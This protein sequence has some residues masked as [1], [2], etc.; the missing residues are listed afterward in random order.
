MSHQKD[1]LS[2][3]RAAEETD[4]QKPPTVL[5][6]GPNEGRSTAQ[7]ALSLLSQV[8]AASEA[9]EFDLA[10]QF[11]EKLLDSYTQESQITAHAVCSTAEALLLTGSREHTQRALDLCLR[12]ETE[13]QHFPAQYRVW[14]L[15][16]KACAMTSVSGNES[17]F[18]TLHQFKTTLDN[19][20]THN[21]GLPEAEQLYAA[22]DMALTTMESLH[23][24]QLGRSVCSVITK[25]VK[26][27]RHE[28]THGTVYLSMLLHS[29][30]FSS[31]VGEAQAALDHLCAVSAL[32]NESVPEGARVELNARRITSQLYKELG[33]HSRAQEELA[34][35]LNLADPSTDSLERLELLVDQVALHS[36]SEQSAKCFSLI[37][38]LKMACYGL[39]PRDIGRAIRSGPHTSPNTIEPGANENIIRVGTILAEVMVH[40]LEQRLESDPKDEVIPVLCQQLQSVDKLLPKSGAMSGISRRILLAR[41]SA[42][43]HTDTSTSEEDIHELE[44]LSLNLRLSDMGR[45]QVKL[46]LAAVHLKN[47]DEHAAQSIYEEQTE[48]LEALKSTQRSRQMLTLLALEGHLLSKLQK[49]EA[50]L[51]TVQ[52]KVN[53]RESL[54]L[55]NCPNCI[56]DKQLLD[57][58]KQRLAE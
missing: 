13:S 5:P 23:F 20:R 22:T 52:L 47:G 41:A 17:A 4:Q 27:L 45:S 58:I 33:Y 26:A 32:L 53:L 31:R 29:G 28:H 49:W 48:V 44:E 38:T 21:P 2:T 11:I 16:L 55:T 19:W 9:R 35:A 3:R 37:S 8:Q 50:L 46:M 7:L 39:L 12:I 1:P 36:A 56:R 15:L 54:G 18:E 42:L 57:L 6:A 10:V 14:G 43:V 24:N 25:F 40:E 30:V 51:Q 34:A